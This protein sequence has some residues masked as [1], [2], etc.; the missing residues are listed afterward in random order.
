MPVVSPE[1]LAVMPAPKPRSTQSVD[2][3]TIPTVPFAWVGEHV[4]A[5]IRGCSVKT[6]QRERQQGIGCRYRKIN[7][8][9]VRYRIGDIHQFLESQPGGGGAVIPEASRRGRGRKASKLEHVPVCS[10]RAA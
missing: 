2:L 5:A 8:A 7:G 9:S 4:Y 6:V 10:G 3:S 1:A